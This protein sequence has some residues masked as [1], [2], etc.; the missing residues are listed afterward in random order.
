MLKS[1]YLAFLPL[2]LL[3]QIVDTLVLFF[4][5]VLSLNVLLAG[6]FALYLSLSALG[7][8]MDQLWKGIF[9]L[10]MLAFYRLSWALLDMF[11]EFWPREM[12]LAELALLWVLFTN[13]P[14]M[15]TYVFSGECL[16]TKLAFNGCH[17]AFP[18]SMG[19]EI[20]T[21]LPFFAERA[22]SCDIEAL[23]FVIR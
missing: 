8:M 16:M 18:I 4:K 1:W 9:V 3:H 22:L 6:S 15:L 14:T 23:C 7:L 17:L 21:H 2:D 20:F 5:K 13:L 19:L 12:F 10:A 11:D